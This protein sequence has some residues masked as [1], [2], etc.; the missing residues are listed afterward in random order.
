M[1]EPGSLQQPAMTR[2]L[3]VT[4]RLLQEKKVVRFGGKSSYKAVRAHCT[5]TT[6]G[7]DGTV[8]GPGDGEDRARS[9]EAGSPIDAG[10]GGEVDSWTVVVWREART[11]T[12]TGELKNP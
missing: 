3:W 12:E 4:W 8:H 5:K 10:H 6:R 9:R 11:R 2:I 7:P 1:L